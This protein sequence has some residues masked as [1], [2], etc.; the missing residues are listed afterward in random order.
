MECGFQIITDSTCDLPKSWVAAHPNITVADVPVIV[1][2]GHESHILR[3]LGPDDFPQA[4]QYVKQ[5]FRASTSHPMMYS[6][7]PGS[8][9]PGVEPLFSIEDTV[10]K[11]A[12][13]GKDVVYVVMNS[14]LS[15]AYGTATPLFA[16]L[17]EEYKG[18]GR[19]IRCVDSQC[20]GTGLGMLLLDITNGIEDGSIKDV[21]DVV[22]FVEKQRGFIG[23]FFTWGELSYIKLSGR[24]SSVGAMIGTLLGVRL[25]CS[26]QYCPDGQRRLEHLTPKHT[27]LIKVRGIGR[28]AEIISLYVKRHIQD[29]TGP[30]IIAHGNVP[31]DARIILS[32]MQSYLPAAKYLVDE[33]RCGAGIQAHGGPTSIHVNFHIDRIGSLAETVKEFESIIK[34]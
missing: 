24:V 5:G 11:N 2:K 8:Y 32:R 29:P 9:G 33:W 14:A 21:D 25:L 23:H 27:D 31:R 18:R 12:E 19:K 7:E 15:G 26:A 6:T 4:E 13:A 34:A 16:Q 30:I 3:D 22:A 20:M 1:T 28:W 17:Q 10:R